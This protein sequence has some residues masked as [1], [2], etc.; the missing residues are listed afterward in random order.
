VNSIDER[1]FIGV[2][3]VITNLIKSV[4]REVLAGQPSH[5]AG[6]PWGAATTDSRPRVPFHCL[7]ETFTAKETHGRLQ[8]EASRPVAHWAHRSVA[9]ARGLLVSGAHPG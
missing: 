7:L 4:T 9:F 8:S 1:V 3:G 6:Q 5:V 2:P